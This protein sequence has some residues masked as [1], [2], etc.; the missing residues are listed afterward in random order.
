MAV[1]STITSEV[2]KASPVFAVAGA[3]F[4]GFSMQE[5][6]YAATFI[7]TI[8][9]AYILIRDKILKRGTK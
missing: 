8:L 1:A 6:F 4:L 7:Y 9:Q 3:S 5:W 2:V